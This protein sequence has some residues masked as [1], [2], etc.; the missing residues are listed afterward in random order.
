MDAALLGTLF[1]VA[2]VAAYLAVPFNPTIPG[3]PL[4]I[5][6]EPLVL[7]LA[8]PFRRYA[9][10]GAAG[11][12]LLHNVALRLSPEITPIFALAQ[13][14]TALAAG[15]LGAFVWSRVHG[16][17]RVTAAPAAFVALFVPVLGL[18]SAVEIGASPIAEM[19]HILE[20]VLVPQLLL[21]PVALAA[22]ELQA[23]RAR[24]AASAEE[25]PG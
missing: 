10:A 8:L 2:F 1:A 24:T 18:A 15:L 16:P 7:I 21:G 6:P 12:V 20:E 22:W 3:T 25:P 14:A 11:G 19:E 4:Q 17:I 9:V 5:R 23:T 13:T